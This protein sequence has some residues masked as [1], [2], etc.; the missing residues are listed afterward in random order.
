MTSPQPSG[1]TATMEP[2]ALAALQRA[3][4]AEH[5]ADWAYGLATAFVKDAQQ[6]ALR[7]GATQHRARRDATERLL[8]DVGATPV[9][10]EPAYAPP[11]PV[12]DQPTAI[13]LLVT[14]ETDTAGAWRAVLERT[15]D[16]NLRRTSLDAL[17]SAAVRATRWR[18]AGGATPLTVPFPGQP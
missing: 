2:E 14:A 8:R 5:A 6:N 12:T 3:L 18:K 7:D 16:A 17:T 15:T 11:Q 9:P 13:T 4:A 1:S 10:A